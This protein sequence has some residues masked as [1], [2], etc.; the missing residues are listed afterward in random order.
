M[1]NA[2]VKKSKYEQVG[3]CHRCEHRALN[4]ENPNYQ[5]R[6]EC[7]D[8][9]ATYACYMYRPI[10]PVILTKVK[11][12]KRAQF[13]GWAFS[14]RSSAFKTPSD[15]VELDLHKLKQGNILYWKPKTKTQDN[16]EK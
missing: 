1:I 13:S 15:K 5:P 7:G 6:C 14:A 10:V 11:G 2:K 9:G 16:K 12:D 3:L 8:K 4:R